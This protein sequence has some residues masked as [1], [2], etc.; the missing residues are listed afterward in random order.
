MK[1]DVVSKVW[2]LIFLL[3]LS[4]PMSGFAQAIQVKGTVLDASGMTVIGASVLEK[5]TTNGVIT[6]MDGNFELSVSPKGTLVISYVGFQTQEIAV[7][8][9]RN[10][11]ITLKED[12]EVLDEVVVVGYG[13]MKK[14]DM[15][16]AI[17]SVD[18]DELTKRTTTNPAEALQGKIAG[19]NIMKSGG[20]AGAGVS[21]KIR[22]VKSFGDNEPLYIIDGFPGDIN[23]VNPVDIQSM[24]VLKDGAAAAIYGSVAANGVVIITTKNGKKGETHI[25]FNTYL[26]MTTVAKRMEFLNAEQYKSTIKQM[27]INAGREDEIPAYCTTDT[28]VDTN[29]QDEMMRNGLSQNYMFSVRGGG[30]TAQYSVSYNHA[31]DKGIFLGNDFRQDNAR[32]K[33]HMSK[34]IFDLDANLGF[35]YTKSHQPTYSL[36]EVYNISPLVPVYDENEKYGFGLTASQGLPSNNNPMADYYYQDETEKTFSTT[37]NVSLGIKITSWLNFKTS[38][39]YRGKHYRYTLHYPDYI[40]NAQQTH[41]YPYNS[42]S[43]YYWEE[44]TIDNIL[45]F[46]KEFGKHSLNAM[47]GSSI[48]S[49]KNTSN[50]VAVEGFATRYTVDKNGNLVSTN[51][52]SGFL[53]P[54]FDTIDAGK[55]G[56]YTG[57]GTK[58]EYNR[59][60]FF[61]RINYNF[62]NRYLIQA[63]MR[64]DGSS[65]F[66]KNNR[67]GCF[68]SIALG[69]RI[70]EEKFF[71]KNTFINNLKF[72]VSW[73]RLG[74]E[75][76]LGYYDFQ[77]LISSYN[78]YYGGYV[79]GSGSN[80]WAGAVAC[81][82]ERNDLKWETT[83]TKNIGF[84]Y[85]MF[86]NRLTGSINYYI[87][88]TEDLLITKKLSPSA[89]YQNPILNVGKIRNRG[90]EL[91]LNW[92]D[93]IK[94]FEYGIGFNLSTTHNE[95]ISLADKGQALYC[96]GLVYGTDYTP[97]YA[98]EGKPIS[99]F[100]LYR[101]DGIF[102]SDAEAAA[103]VNANGERLQPNAKAGDIRFKDINGDGVLDENDREYCGTGIPKV[104]A[105]LNLTAGYKG[106]DLSL[107]FG[108]AWGHKLFNGNRYFYESMQ[109]PGQMLTSVLDAWTPTNTDTDMPRAVLNDPNRN[110][111]ESDRFLENGNFVRLRQAQLGYTLPTNILKKAYIEKLRFYISGENLFTITKYSGTDPEFSRS[112]PLDTGIDS[113]IFPFTRSFTVG[114]Q[115]TF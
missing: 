31:D 59:A 45:N 53:D 101:T 51:E 46:N 11:K 89:G 39:A 72:R 73:G 75:N 7:N 55:G 17:S 115:L 65:K 114:A 62:D 84:D 74:N 109:T 2:Q 69:W 95:V 91:E 10:F 99:A 23:S 104:E 19:V 70:S 58:Y 102:Q 98:T 12:T 22:G 1:K 107:L 27:Y 5:G 113:Y 64:Y 103:Y 110:A 82:M 21:V 8:N 42:E 32:M 63:T 108:S 50:G 13:T 56:T 111:R 54:S 18:V 43:T 87:N 77:A 92:N 34:Y 20:N 38:Y 81:N 80:P 24:E 96:T 6:D 29:W 88:Q 15:T 47:I 78:T 44:Q 57:E 97:A 9:Q 86:N 40:S 60:S 71:P 112:S 100:Y 106:F 105:N 4:I 67:W 14:S 33:L 52:P 25:D 61:G 90:F 28:G 68:P 41:L 35:R 48:T 26:S 3:A 37:A 36:K 66:G 16:G 49:T 79:Q 30:E 85:A 94:D 76:A 93:R 83:D